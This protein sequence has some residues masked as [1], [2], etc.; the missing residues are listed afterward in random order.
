MPSGIAAHFTTRVARPVIN[1]IPLPALNVLTML[2]AHRRERFGGSNG[3]LKFRQDGIDYL[4]TDGRGS[5]TW[6][7]SDVQTIA[8]ANPWEFRITGYREIAEFDLKQSLSRELFDRL[9]NILYAA[10]LN[11]APGTEGHRQ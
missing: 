7:W 10:D 8:S 9:W 4:A 3:T 5:R 1:G 2:P 6:R 11:V